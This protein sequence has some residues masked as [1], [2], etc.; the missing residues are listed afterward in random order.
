M[1]LGEKFFAENVRHI[2][3][4]FSTMNVFVILWLFNYLNSLP[5][6]KIPKSRSAANVKLLRTAWLWHAA[7]HFLKVNLINMD[8][9]ED[10]TVSSSS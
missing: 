8:K 1:F 4:F 9:T 5:R 6:I 7:S 3:K 10:T 2:L